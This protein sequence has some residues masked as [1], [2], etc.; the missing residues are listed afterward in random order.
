MEHLIVGTVAE[1]VSDHEGE[2]LT[3]NPNLQVVKIQNAGMHP[4]GQIGKA[5]PPQKR[6]LTV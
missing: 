6:D 2:P 1:L 3:R 5:G 4:T